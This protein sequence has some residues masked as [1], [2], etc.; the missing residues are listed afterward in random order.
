M[1]SFV[2]VV[3][4]TCL[5]VVI[6]FAFKPFYEN[7]LHLMMR[8]SYMH[9]VSNRFKKNTDFLQKKLTWIN[10]SPLLYNL[11]LLLLLLSLWV[12]NL[13]K[14][15]RLFLSRDVNKHP[16]LNHPLA[17][18]S[19]LSQALDF[20]CNLCE[21]VLVE[22]EFIQGDPY[23]IITSNWILWERKIQL[24]II[25]LFYMG[26]PV[27]IDTSAHLALKLVEVNRYFDHQIHC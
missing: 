9:I 13:K 10:F 2:V 23:K 19:R 21:T 7:F 22:I 1:D 14:W 3:W 8:N 24:L 25:K 6:F 18:L 16:H 20:W 15:P 11:S 26:Q 5:P 27:Y 17:W 4:S 12:K